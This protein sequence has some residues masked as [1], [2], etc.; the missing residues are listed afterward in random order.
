MIPI[1]SG[2]SSGGIAS[3]KAAGRVKAQA[4]SSPALQAQQQEHEDQKTYPGH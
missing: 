4:N 1:S 3:E 2:S